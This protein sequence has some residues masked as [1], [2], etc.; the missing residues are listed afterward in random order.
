MLTNLVWLIVILF[1]DAIIRLS[2]A[3]YIERRKERR[4]N[5]A[6]KELAGQLDRAVDATRAKRAITTSAPTG[7]N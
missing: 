6:A 5:L 3:L 7:V 4:F 2:I 1:G